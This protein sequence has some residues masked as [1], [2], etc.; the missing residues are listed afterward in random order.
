MKLLFTIVL[1]SL[2]L[3]CNKKRDYNE[4]IK[5]D[6]KSKKPDSSTPGSKPYTFYFEDSICSV[7]SPFFPF[8]KY[9]IAGDIIT[10]SMDS[11]P[12]LE[13]HYPSKYKILQLDDDSL[14]VAPISPLATYNSIFRLG[15]IKPKNTLVP[16]VIYF[17]SSPCYGSCPSVML[18]IDSTG[19]LLFYGKNL[20]DTGL[21]FKG[22]LNKTQYDIIISKIQNLPL[23]SLKEFYDA[24]WSDDQYCGV[25][26]IT[27]QRRIN[28]TAY[29]YDKEPV[30]LRLLLKYLMVLNQRLPLKATNDVDEAYF[31]MNKDLQILDHDT[32][33]PVLPPVLYKNKHKIKA[34]R[35][36]H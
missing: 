8:T 26:I 13:E 1:L 7:I 11:F 18:E 21:I 20:P 10:V 32:P 22:S 36:R 34:G 31:I 12:G 6:W 24:G 23:D 2:L 33:P 30:E 3:G 19:R 27:K 35:P 14:I 4:L 17:R 29:G 15:K 16:L 9:T 5:G 28:S 25:N